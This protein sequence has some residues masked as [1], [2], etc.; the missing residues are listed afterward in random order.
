MK[1]NKHISFSALTVYFY[2]I[3][4]FFLFNSFCLL[5]QNKEAL[6]YE[7]D[8][9][10][11]SMDYFSKDALPRG[12]EF[13]RIDS[14]YYVGWM[15]EGAF[16]YDHA[17]DYLGFK[18][19]AEQLDKAALLIEKDFKK[20][21]K[22]RTADVYEYIKI[23]QLH[24][25]WDFIAYYLMNCYSNMEMPEK[26]WALLLKCK[27]L[28]MQD[29]FN[30]DTYSYMAWTVHR[31]RFYTNEKYSFLK[32]NLNENEQYANKLLDSCALKIKR[33]A[34]LNKNFFN[35]DY[36]KNK[37]PT[38]WHYKSI[39]YSYQLNIPSGSYYYEKLRNTGYF[40]ENNY[41]TFCAIQGKFEEAAHYYDISK[42]QDQG[43]KRMK[44]SYY[45]SSVLST[46]KNDNKS[47]IEELKNLIKVNGSTPGFGWYNIALARN[48]LYDGQNN[49]AKK[50]IDKASQFKEIH[51]GTT[52]GQSHYDFSVSL[53]QLIQ[54][55][56]EISALKYLHKNWWYNPSLLSEIT[57]LNVEKFS[58]QFLII[59]QF[60]SNPERNNVIYKLFST[61]STVSYDEI[62]QMIAG[63]STKYFIKKFEEESQQ[64]TRPIIRRYF[65]LLTAMLYMKKEEYEK[66]Q[67]ILLTLSQ[68]KTIDSDYE[69]LF[70][71]RIYE[72]LIKC[73]KELDNLPKK[74]YAG[75]L[76][77]YPQL[78]PYSDI[79]IPLRLI[80]NEQS[81]TEKEMIA[82]LKNTNIEWK[83]DLTDEA[84]DLT[85]L[86]GKKGNTP[87]I[88]FQLKWKNYI[89]TPL[90][91]IAYLQVDDIKKQL[92]F[93]IFNIGNDEKK[94]EI[95][96][97]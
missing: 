3:F 13:K 87:T 4:S 84:G 92:P 9:K 85:L 16:K 86:F 7:I 77:N 55:S 67:K 76:Q 93:Y 46:Y 54:K 50:Y 88:K 45:Y 68:D 18:I 48:F 14:S 90:T 63:F 64:D 17:A 70:L 97:K 60:A 72:S 82:Q 75:L 69:K 78:V 27:N 42:K 5:A 24:R 29:E 61:E 58:L 32:K 44:E 47:G 62:W 59:N 83:T 25:D 2:F 51:I 52:L 23:M 1:Y 20:S 31:N 71:G 89:V 65:K 66:A 15:L 28:D 8:A 34:V 53:L 91:E 10:R 30:L 43:D 49:L 81:E 37:M 35:I 94:M 12:R 26:V 38:V 79:K 41:A 57:K 6:R 19:A 40:P 95:L 74:Y 96:D 73:E 56:R 33:D 22:T 80:S 36:E 39:L 11:G 21:L